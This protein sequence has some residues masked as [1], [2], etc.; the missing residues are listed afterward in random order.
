MDWMC[1]EKIGIMGDDWVFCLN[2]G[3]NEWMSLL[4][5]ERQDVDLS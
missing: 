2:N 4:R 1:E 5:W 3:V